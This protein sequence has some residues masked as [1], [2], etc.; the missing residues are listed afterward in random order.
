MY[1][2][3]VLWMDAGSLESRHRMQGGGVVLHVGQLECIDL[4]LGLDEEPSER[5]WAVT[6][7]Q[8]TTVT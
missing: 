7:E 6:K 2:A 5:F 8:S 4:C 3:G 1:P